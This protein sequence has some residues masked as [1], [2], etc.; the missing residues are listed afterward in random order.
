MPSEGPFVNFAQ[1]WL[2]WQRPLRNR[3]K[4]VQINNIHANTFHFVVKK[5]IKIGPVEAEIPLLNLKTEEITESKI[6][7]PVGK[8][9]ERVK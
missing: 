8:F 7:S 1:N 6:Y 2:P 5:I 4:L 3:K 9:A